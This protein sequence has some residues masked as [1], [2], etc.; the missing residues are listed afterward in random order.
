MRRATKNLMMVA[1][2]VSYKGLMASNGN[3]LG[4]IYRCSNKS[5]IYANID[6]SK[7]EVSHV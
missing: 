3:M 5:E 4:V 2:S 7:K 6:K 1:E